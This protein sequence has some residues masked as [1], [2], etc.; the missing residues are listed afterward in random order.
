MMGREGGGRDEDHR[1]FFEELWKQH[2]AS[3]TNEDVDENTLEHDVPL[4][5]QRCRPSSKLVLGAGARTSPILHRNPSTT[6]LL[7]LRILMLAKDAWA[8]TP[9]SEKPK[10]KRGTHQRNKRSRTGLLGACIVQSFW[11]FTMQLNCEK[12]M[13]PLPLLSELDVQLVLAEYEL[14]V[15]ELWEEEI[16]RAWQVYNEQVYNELW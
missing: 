8:H 12:R 11:A 5:R 9:R 4:P 7:V 10:S 16:Q 2:F 3:I 13:R 14:S 1:N 15:L 6:R